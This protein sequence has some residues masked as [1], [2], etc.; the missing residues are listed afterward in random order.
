MTPCCIFVEGHPRKL[1]VKFHWIWPCSF[2][3]FLSNCWRKYRPRTKTNHNSSPVMLCWTNKISIETH[4]YLI[5]G[6]VCTPTNVYNCHRLELTNLENKKRLF[7]NFSWAIR[8]PV[9][10][11]K[12]RKLYDKMAELE[13]MVN[14]SSMW[15]RWQCRQA[16][17]HSSRTIIRK[18]NKHK[19]SQLIC[20]VA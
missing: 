13:K 2:R 1:P 15:T 6:F 20:L 3:V 18:S 9:L 5:L 11:S 8:L 4:T 17:K 7:Y 12:Q 19:L 16:W 14:P 10:M